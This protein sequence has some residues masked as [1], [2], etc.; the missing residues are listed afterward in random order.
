VDLFDAEKDAYPYEDGHFDT[1]LCCELVEHLYHDPMHMMS[2]INRILKPGGHLMLTTPNIT[3][4][5]ALL[6]VLEA[7]HPGFFHTFV[8]PNPD[9]SFDPRHNREYAPRDIHLMFPAAGFEVQRMETG[10]F[11]EPDA[12]DRRRNQQMI[13]LLRA[14]GDT[15][16]LREDCMYVIGRKTGPVRDRWPHGL[17]E[18]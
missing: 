16:A 2:E 4:L 8:K 11:H 5:R 10:W 9:G 14:R 3:N 6:A 15:V 12:V 1:V 18:S 7:W 13:A 17:Y